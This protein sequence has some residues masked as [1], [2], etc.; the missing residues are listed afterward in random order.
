MPEFRLPYALFF[1]PP[2]AQSGSPGN[3]VAWRIRGTCESGLK[4]GLDSDG[5]WNGARRR[6]FGIS[7]HLLRVI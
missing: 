1:D 7:L 4:L 3:R 6:R 5:R 2:I